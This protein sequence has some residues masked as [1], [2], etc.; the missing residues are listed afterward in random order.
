[1]D[2][3]YAPSLF[4]RQV[5]EAGIALIKEFEGLHLVPYLCPGGVWTIGYGHTRTVRAGMKITEAEADQFLTEDLRLVGAALQR[6]VLVPLDDNEFAALASFVFNVGSGSFQ[7][8]QLL[9]LL[10][11][12]WYDQVPAQFLRWNRAGGEVMG[13]LTRRRLAEGKLWSTPMTQEV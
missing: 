12:G 2:G 1:M 9:S 7:S 5:N 8:S 3:T 13:G 6:L 11:R 4:A 10:N